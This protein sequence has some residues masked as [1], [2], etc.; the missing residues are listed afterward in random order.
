MGPSPKQQRRA[1]APK[2]K[3]AVRAKSG[4]YT[5]RIR[6]K[7]CDEQADE[8]GHC[9]TCV[10]LQLQCLGFGAKRPEWLRENRNVVELREKIKTFLAAQGKIK[11]HSGS[12]PR[13]S[14]LEPTILPLTLEHSSSSSSPRT[15]TL[16][17][18]SGDEMHVRSQYH[19]M[20]DIHPYAHG[21]SLH[22]MQE[23]SPDSPLPPS[24]GP[25][26][27]QDLLLPHYQ[28]SIM[29]P[30]LDSWPNN[31][32]NS[33]QL[34]TYTSP[35]ITSSFSASYNRNDAYFEEEEYPLA[36]SVGVSG[37]FGHNRFMPRMTANSQD[38]L[39]SHYMQNVLKIQYLHADQSIDSIVWRLI[40]ES[41]SA[42]D[43]ACL[44]SD[45]HRKSIQRVGT[46]D[47]ENESQALLQR[48]QRMP[49]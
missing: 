46:Y 39:L 14:D 32:A 6:R 16:S 41:D 27:P 22:P 11:G 18:S 7:K 29:T 12:G 40:N 45:L 43:A 10:R 36:A 44:L 1:G 42:R 3:G 2:A 31:Q 49:L 9:Q 13:S 38:L 28:T 20:R 24:R 47:D 26:Y 35:A 15:P 17:V 37:D 23:L 5:C 21:T 33:S 25:L 4:C 30:S 19:P 34:T 8:K 48:V